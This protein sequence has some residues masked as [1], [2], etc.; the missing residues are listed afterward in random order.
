MI[1]DYVSAVEHIYNKGAKEF[2]VDPEK[3]C[4]MGGSGGGFVVTS[5]NTM[6]SRRKN[7]H[8]LKCS[9]V[10]QPV[11]PYYWLTTA[12]EN[13]LR[14]E[15]LVFYDGPPQTKPEKLISLLKFSKVSDKSLCFLILS[16]S[17]QAHRSKELG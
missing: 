16:A 8:M 9:L 1:G 6:L 13:M 11:I 4:S 14:Q 17:W 10:Y 7:S 2:G 3:L 15:K 5:A 12:K